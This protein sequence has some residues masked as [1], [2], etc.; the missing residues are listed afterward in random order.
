MKIFAI[1]MICVVGALLLALLWYMLFGMIVFNMTFA[2]R[3]M[4]K[5]RRLQNAEYYGIDLEWWNRHPFDKVKIKNKDGLELVGFLHNAHSDKTAI[6]V[7]GYMS[8]H[9]EMQGIC[10][11]YLRRRFNVLAVDNRAHGESEGRCIGFGYYDRL[12][13]LLW[14]EY[15]NKNIGGKI[16]LQGL[17]MGATAVCCVS[18]EDLPKNVVAIVSDCG[19]ANGDRQVSYVNRQNKVPQII[20]KH[21]YSY[22]KR[23]HGFDMNKVDAT[24]IV[25]KTK[26]PI[27]FI[28]GDA[29]NFV[30]FENMEILYNATPENKRDKYVVSGAGHA[31]AMKTAGKAYEKRIDKF[32]ADFTD[33]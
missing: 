25:C 11:F 10:D 24:K 2:K 16:V 32:L 6:I 23:V 29:D 26:V 18:G 22:L 5:K 28:H 13:L 20:K 27:L 4:S 17:S 12:D 31:L 1:I 7:H 30:P 21:L 8:N 9:S 15:V 14:I 3:K 19:F 33:L